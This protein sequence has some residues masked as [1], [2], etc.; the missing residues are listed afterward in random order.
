MASPA[1]RDGIGRHDGDFK[2][3]GFPM[4]HETIVRAL[5]AIERGEKLVQATTKLLAEQGYVN[6]MEVTRL[7]S[8]EPE[9]RAVAITEKGELLLKRQKE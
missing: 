1:K 8:L 6:V 7:E 9:Y 4:D 5:E 3:R 2:I